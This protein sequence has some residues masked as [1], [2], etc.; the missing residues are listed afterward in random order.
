MAVFPNYKPEEGYRSGFIDNVKRTTSESGSTQIRDVWGVEK[1]WAEGT[2][3]V[4]TAQARILKA[5]Y[6]AN[7]TITFDFF[8]F[9]DDQ[10]TTEN[11]GTGDGSN[12]TFTIPA[13][14]TSGHLVYV[15]AVLKTLTTHYTIS[16]GT[17]S[18]GEDQVIFEAA[19]KPGNGLAVT[20]TYVGLHRYTVEFM[21]THTREPLIQPGRKRV[22]IRVEEAF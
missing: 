2:W 20:V 21:S 7:K 12:D 16:V 9:D 15:D 19:H 13:K 6:D 14:S 22:S 11:I 10:F 17:G 4:T 3:N 1:F 18:K 8:D 5:F